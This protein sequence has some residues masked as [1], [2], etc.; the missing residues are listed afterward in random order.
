MTYNVLNGMLHPAIPYNTLI[1]FYVFL[2]CYLVL[3]IFVLLVANKWLAGKIPCERNNLSC[4]VWGVK[5][6]CTIPISMLENP[7]YSEMA[8]FGGPYLIWNYSRSWLIE[9]E[10]S[11]SKSMTGKTN[12][13]LLQQSGLCAVC[14][15]L[16]YAESVHCV[17]CISMKHFKFHW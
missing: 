16:G 10:S 3:V 9:T 13:E 12:D 7:C 4:V 1:V 11:H 2:C 5:P 6:N 15:L 14:R 17:V 8:S